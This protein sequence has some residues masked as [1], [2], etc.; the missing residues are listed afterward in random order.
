[1]FCS[2]IIA[3]FF[4][5]QWWLPHSLA[6][7]LYY[8]KATNYVIFSLVTWSSSNLILFWSLISIVLQFSFLSILLSILIIFYFLFFIL[9][10]FQETTLIR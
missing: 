9:I 2:T 4:F 6:R 5:F 10:F 8:L 1:L 3:R 7:F